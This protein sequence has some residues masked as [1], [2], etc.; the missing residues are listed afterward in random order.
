MKIY[1][2]VRIWL[3]I[4]IQWLRPYLFSS[5]EQHKFTLLE[6]RANAAFFGF[7]FKELSDEEITK[8]ID[9]SAKILSKLGCTS[10][11]V[12]EVVKRMSQ[13]SAVPK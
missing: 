6:F 10:D 7:D 12:S 9:G 8:S 3:A 1:H 2:K 11:E 5:K 13:L 4:K